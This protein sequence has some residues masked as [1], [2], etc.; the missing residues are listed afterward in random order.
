M[1]HNPYKMDNYRT[2]SVSNAAET[3]SSDK[4]SNRSQKLKSWAHD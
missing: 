1:V 2:T 4:L 3:V